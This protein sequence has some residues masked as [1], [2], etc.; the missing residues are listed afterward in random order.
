MPVQPDV[1][2]RYD[3]RNTMSL[4]TRQE[5]V[6]LAWAPETGTVLHRTFEAHATLSLTAGV[7][8]SCARL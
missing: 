8:A 4:E 6:T 1:T 2:L 5:E 7:S 3:D